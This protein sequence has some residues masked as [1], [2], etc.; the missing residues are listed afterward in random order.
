MGEEAQSRNQCEEKQRLNVPL[1]IVPCNRLSVIS[2]FERPRAWCGRVSDATRHS[3]EV[4]KDLSLSA[5]YNRQ[6]LRTSVHCLRV[7]S[8]FCEEIF[9]R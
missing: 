6:S 5:D 4:L 1:P 9:R 8:S 3:D 2:Y 7:P